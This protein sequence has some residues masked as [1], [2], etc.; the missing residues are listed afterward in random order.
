MIYGKRN[1][2]EF[3]P[4]HKQKRKSDNADR[5]DRRRP[6]ERAVVREQ[7]TNRTIELVARVHAAY[8]AFISGVYARIDANVFGTMF[9]MTV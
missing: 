1:R 3:P 4:T 9:A 7:S 5:K 2:R 6:H 8:N